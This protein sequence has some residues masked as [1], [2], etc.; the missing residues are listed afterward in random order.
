MNRNG[1]TALHLEGRT[2]R[3]Q[4]GR[5]MTRADRCTDDE[6][7]FATS[8]DRCKTCWRV[9]SLRLRDRQAVSP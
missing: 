7:L 9:Y 3:S 1:E 4:C 6:A 8:S 2:G 5:K